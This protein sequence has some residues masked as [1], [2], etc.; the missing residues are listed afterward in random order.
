[1]TANNSLFGFIL[2]APA[3]HNMKAAGH[4]EMDFFGAQP[5]DATEA[6]I[7]TTPSVRMRLFYLRLKFE[8]DKSNLELL[9][10]QYHDL[11]AWGGAGFYPH[12][13]AFL[14]LAG[15]VYHRQPQIRL[16]YSI[17]LC[18]VTIDVAANATAS[19]VATSI[20]ANENSPVYAAM[21]D[22]GGVDTLVL[23]ARKTGQSSDFSV[24]ASALTGGQI[25]A[26]DPAYQRIGPSLNA[27]Y[28]L[29]D[30]TVDRPSETN[31]LTNAIP[32][33]TLTLKGVTSGPV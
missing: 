26:E 17:P 5:T 31:T 21:I 13:I 22:N 9:A 27:A 2:A 25:G 8:F 3:W 16:T 4:A 15:E 10:G 1:M 14:G 20:N 30:D 18:C 12:S 6:T 24:D 19:D 23:S 29:D 32:G 33:E 7:Y 28:R 11:F